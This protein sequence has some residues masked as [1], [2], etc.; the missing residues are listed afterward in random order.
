MILI[1]KLDRGATP[2]QTPREIIASSNGYDPEDNVPE[3]NSIFG[4]KFD[5]PYDSAIPT[6]DNNL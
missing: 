1:G 3:I 6:A 5:N 4:N 2:S